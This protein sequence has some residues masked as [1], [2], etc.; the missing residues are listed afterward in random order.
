MASVT[1][2]RRV[3]PLHEASIAWKQQAGEPAAIPEPLVI[4]VEAVAP[5]EAAA[6]TV[7]AVAVEEIINI[8]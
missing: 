7:L 4:G 3:Q 2:R 1:G 6:D 8:F 5:E